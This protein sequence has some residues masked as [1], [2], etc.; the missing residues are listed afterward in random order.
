LTYFISDPTS[1]TQLNA[2]KDYLERKKWWY[3]EI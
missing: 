1:D 2:M 3:K